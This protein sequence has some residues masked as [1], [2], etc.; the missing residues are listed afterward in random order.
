MG[1]I[2]CENSAFADG[3]FRILAESAHALCFSRKNA[4]NHVVVACNRGAEPFV[5]ALPSP[6]VEL[7]SGKRA[8]KGKIAVPCDGVMIWRIEDVQKNLGKLDEKQKP[9]K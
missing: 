5:V 4:K 8:K 3:D 7:V 1:A 9:R 6:A 2:R